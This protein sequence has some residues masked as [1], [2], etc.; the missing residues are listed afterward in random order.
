MRKIET[1]LASDPERVGAA[2]ESNKESDG[3]PDD[4]DVRDMRSVLRRH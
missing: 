2:L 4:G 3:R 1:S